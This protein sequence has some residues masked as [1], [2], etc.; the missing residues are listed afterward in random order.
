MTHHNRADPTSRWSWLLASP[1]FVGSIMVLAVNDRVLKHEFPGLVT[2]KLS[3]FAGVA[4]VAIAL[5]LIALLAFASIPIGFFAQR[6]RRWI[7]GYVFADI[8]AAAALAVLCFFVLVLESLSSG[9]GAF[10]AFWIVIQI[11]TI[12]A[13]ALIVF[14]AARALPE[15]STESPPY[16]PVT[17]D[18][19]PSTQP[20][21]PRP[22]DRRD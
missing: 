2:G 3:D 6:S 15:A 5:G 20:P 12:C 7:V 22:V 16:P 14:L 11:A 21:P 17:F 19:A 9:A 8:G 18:R 13:G 4:M 1:M 10:T